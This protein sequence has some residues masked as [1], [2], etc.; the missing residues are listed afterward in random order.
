MEQDSQL[1]RHGNHGLAL[2]LLTSTDRQ[3]KTQLSEC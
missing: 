1:T 3:V 2:G